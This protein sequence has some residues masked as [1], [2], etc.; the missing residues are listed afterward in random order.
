MDNRSY[1][2]WGTLQLGYAPVGMWQEVL[3][4]IPELPDVEPSQSTCALFSDRGIFGHQIVSE[5]H[6][7][8]DP[9]PR[10]KQKLLKKLDM[11]E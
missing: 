10:T 2:R 6:F 3:Y 5:L 7:W 9:V 8:S 1:I 11:W 4:K